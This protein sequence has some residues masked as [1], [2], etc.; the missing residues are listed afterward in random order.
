MSGFGLYGRWPL[1]FGRSTIIPG[2]KSSLKLYMYIYTWNFMH[3]RYFQLIVNSIILCG[4][5]DIL[6][7]FLLIF[8]FILF[9][10][11]SLSL[12]LPKEPFPL[13]ILLIRSL[14]FCNLSS[15]SSYL[16]LFTSLFISKEPLLFSFSHSNKWNHKL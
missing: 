11:P 10:S 12:P 14:E 3:Y 7:V 1:D 15:P 4:F 16:L 6:L 8:L 5:S 13:P 9:P 2:E